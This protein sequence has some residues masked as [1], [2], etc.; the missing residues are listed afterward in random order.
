MY[1]YDRG[2]PAYHQY[3]P[4]RYR[5][6]VTAPVLHPEQLQNREHR[7][8]HQSGRHDRAEQPQ[9]CN[10]CKIC[11]YTQPYPT[12]PIPVYHQHFSSLRL[13]ELNGSEISNSRY[14]CPSCKSHHT[15]YPEPRVKI[16]VSDST[17]HQFFAPPG[18]LG[19]DYSGDIQ[20]SDYITIPEACIE[21][22][23]HAFRLDYEQQLHNKAMDVVLVAGY[24]DLVK[25]HCREFILHGMKEFASAV[26][27]IGKHIHPDS[28][29]TVTIAGLM[30]PPRLAWF[31]DN[32]KEPVGYVNRM[33][34]IDWL[35]QEIKQLNYSNSVPNYPG[36]RTFG[37]RKVT[38]RWLDTYGQ[39]HH[40]EIQKHRWE[41]WIGSTRSG[42]LHLTSEMRFT[43][44]RAINNYF[45]TR[46]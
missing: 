40:R 9:D 44:G 26:K 45:I 35:N 4:T 10:K 24:N 31:H 8:S 42:K 3:R 18:H 6:Y 36:L 39:E 1:R 37:V 16:V 23:V 29:N 34:K 33:E 15:P 25:G 41:Q 7:H 17:L 11:S 5:P 46:T 43:V 12:E 32:G 20:H 30:Y 28:T 22:L 2:A 27:Q 38:R 19:T 14:L 21:D 13:R